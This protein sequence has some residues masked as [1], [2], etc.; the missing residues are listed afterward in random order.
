[1]ET[2]ISIIVKDENKLN[3]LRNYFYDSKNLDTVKKFLKAIY[4]SEDLPYNWHFDSDGNTSQKRLDFID[5]LT[6]GEN[7]KSNI[8]KENYPT[9]NSPEFNLLTEFWAYSHEQNPTIDLGD[10]KFSWEE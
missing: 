4:N 5:S 1:M 7:L 6:S 10:H 8:K 2:D 3:E 9:G